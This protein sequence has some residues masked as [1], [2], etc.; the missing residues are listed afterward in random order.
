MKQLPS[1]RPRPPVALLAVGLGAAACGSGSAYE[2]GWTRAG[3]TTPAPP[4]PR[5]RLEGGGAGFLGRWRGEANASLALGVGAA[6]GEPLGSGSTPIELVLEA[7]AG[8]DGEGSIGGWL[9][10]GGGSPPP[11]ATDGARGYPVGLDYGAFMTEAAPIRDDGN[12]VGDGSGLPPLEGFRYVLDS[13]PVEDGS[14]GTLRV[15]Y[16]PASYL[17]S[18]CALQA[19]H[20]HPDGSYRALPYAPGGVELGADG[21]DSACSAFGP[22]DLSACPDSLAALPPD[23]YLD[24]YLSCFQPGPVLYQM[25]CDRVFLSQFCSCNPGLCRKRPP[26]ED[27][28]L[29][30]IAEGDALIGSFEGATRLGASEPGASVP[31][32]RLERVED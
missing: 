31:S 2:L 9:T 6:A 30:L 27:T 18:W 28:G 24:V 19:P 16:D 11:P 20:P 23:E 17:G 29:M 7:R 21:T 26:R 13:S 14:A 32:V 8:S 10:F 4:G 3:D 1:P 25:S 5:G 22:A 15:T 12:R